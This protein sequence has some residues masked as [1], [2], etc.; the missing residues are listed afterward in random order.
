MN[1]REGS[2]ARLVSIDAFRAVVMLLMIVVND[3]WTL[4]HIPGWV[5]HFPAD[6]DGLGLADVVFPA[7]LFIVGLSVPFAIRSR[8]KKGDDTWAIS[9]HIVLRAAALIIMGVF[10]VNLEF[11]PES[12]LLPKGI[13][14]IL[15][16]LAFFLIW[17]NYREPDTWHARIL[18]IV[19]WVLLAVLVFLYKPSAA[20]WGSIAMQPHWWGI[21]GLIGWSYGLVSLVFLYTGGRVGVQVLVFLFFLLFNMGA[22]SPVLDGFSELKKYVWIVG[23]GSMAASAACGTILSLLYL[24]WKDVSLARFVYYTLTIALLLLLGGQWARQE[25][26]VSKIWA[27]P[28][29][30][31]FSAGMSAGAF[32]VV[33]YITDVRR[34]TDWY[35]WIRPAGTSTL[36][37]YLLPYFFYA[38]LFFIPLGLPEWMRTGGVGIL[39]S[40]F[41]AWVVIALAGQLEKRR[42]NL[43]L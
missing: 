31:L 39:K 41:F 4:I 7:F 10:Q 12:A 19:G 22:Q 1:S 42:L 35:N 6:K 24:R 29:F 21:L 40:L 11:Y 43:K 27:T 3:I 9:I 14:Q 16:T 32:A 2:K 34:W 18:K 30:T 36:T 23:D 37:C 8:R 13:W 20:H 17:L 26:I 25:W 15:M 5:G 28:S 33:V 38:L